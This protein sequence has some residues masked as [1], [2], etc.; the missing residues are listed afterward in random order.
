VSTGPFVIVNRYAGMCWSDAWP[1]DCLTFPDQQTAD[2]Y[3]KAGRE[4]LALDLDES[5]VMP[6]AQYLIEYGRQA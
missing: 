5:T 1:D 6:L 3:V 4:A 2:V